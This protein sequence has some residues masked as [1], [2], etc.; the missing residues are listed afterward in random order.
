[1]S[2]LHAALSTAVG[3]ALIGL[4]GRDIFGAL[5]HPEGRG[6]FRQRMAR[7][8]W[9]LFRLAPGRSPLLTLAGP[10]AVVV[11]IATWAALLLL[12]WTL[13]IWPHMPEGF[14]F[15]GAEPGGDFLEAFNL[16]IVTLTTLGFGDVTPKADAL[17]VIVPFEALLGFGLLSAS[18]SKVLQIYPVLSRRRSLAYEIS[19]L[20]QA[21]AEAAPALE[22]LPPEAVERLYT[23]LTSCLIAVERDLVSFPIAY[24]FAD[25]DDRFSL[26]AVAPYLLELAQRGD[27]DGMPDRVRFR[28]RVLLESVADLAS[29]TSGFHGVR[30]ATAAEMLDAYARDHLKT[31]RVRG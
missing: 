17:R 3:V 11:V 20:R 19:L 8:I 9:R 12:G 13:V 6:I 2:T 5:F 26:P 16:S 10:V 4:T 18:V 7:A 31:E 14:H 25:A 15:G 22:R 28:A 27:R 24:Y 1:M 29:T 30:A 21:E 23:E